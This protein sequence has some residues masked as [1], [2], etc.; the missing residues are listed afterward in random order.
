MIN[1]TSGCSYLSIRTNITNDYPIFIPNSFTPNYDG[2][3]DLFLVYGEGIIKFEMSI[4]DRWHKKIFTTNDQLTGWDGM[5]RGEIVKND[6]YLY[7]I[8]YTTYDNK[9]RSK[10]GYVI[11]VRE[12]Y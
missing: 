8:N 11:V 6:S 2:L 1:S 3:N 10:T 12:D 5:Y 9:K 4:Y 7:I